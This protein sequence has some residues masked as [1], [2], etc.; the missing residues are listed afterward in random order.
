MNGTGEVLVSELRP[1]VAADVIAIGEG[2]RIGIGH[3]GGAGRCLL[4]G[5]TQTSHFNG[6]RTVFDRTWRGYP[7]SSGK[8]L[9]C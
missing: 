4:S 2:V 5:A 6:V 9:G 8:D 1:T 7:P 3:L